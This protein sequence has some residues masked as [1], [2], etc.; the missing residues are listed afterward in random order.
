MLFAT[1][2]RTSTNLATVSSERHL[3]SYSVAVSARTFVVGD[4]HG[5]LHQLTVLL[6]R[7][8]QLGAAD[9]LVFLGDYL[10]RGPASAAVIAHIRSL[11]T[12]AAAKVVA[13]RGN[14]EDA[15]LDVI[16]KGW[17]E[18]LLPRGN[19]CLET[20]RSYLGTP[21]SQAVCSADEFNAMLRGAFFPAADV[22]WMRTLLHY[23]EDDHAIYVHAGLK[24]ERGPDGQF[25]H[26]ANV[27][28]PKLMLWMRD[29]DFFTNYRGKLVVFGH[30]A[31]TTLP[32]ELSTY[33]PADPTDLWAGPAC[34]GLDTQCGKGGFL[35][36]LEL[37]AR[38]VY[39]S[40]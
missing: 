25:P 7:L 1:Q 24:R 22:A 11:Q 32:A 13:L 27:D 40:R 38:R 6:A 10:D 18:F 8:P 33:T 2:L 12:T 14:H 4:I 5:D 9:T 34:I 20:V 39:E 29:R 36:A 21:Q 23:Y 26:P 37:P 30:T 16:D 3:P 15:W 28:P 17:P 35:T 31:T 19:G